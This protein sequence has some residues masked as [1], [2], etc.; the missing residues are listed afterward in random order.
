MCLSPLEDVG[1]DGT[2]GEDHAE[3]LGVAAGSSGRDR[4][5]GDDRR[6]GHRNRG[7][8]AIGRLGDR[9]VGDG[10][11]G[12]VDRRLN[13]RVVGRSRVRHGDGLD[14]DVDRGGQSRDGAG[15][16]AGG[17][18]RDLGGR[19]RDVSLDGRRNG[20]L[21]VGRGGRIVHLGGGV[22][23]LRD[24]VS[25]LD[26]DRADGGLAGGSDG[27]VDGAVAGAVGDFGRAA[28]DGAD[29]SCSHSAGGPGVLG[30]MGLRA[31]VNPVPVIVAGVVAVVDDDI[32]GRVP[33]VDALMAGPL[34]GAEEAKVDIDAQGKV[35]VEVEERS[36]G[37]DGHDG[38]GGGSSLDH[39]DG[40]EIASEKASD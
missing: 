2:C 17:V 16:D 31:R 5:D 6:G 13:G 19:L 30:L 32:V 35:D 11:N 25:S 7:V 36:L 12:S 8:V 15:P 28:D 23:H 24:R 29:V 37:R 14:G 20:D 27:G 33:E 9:R 3:V 18:L 21:G 1:G 39:F 4:R 22:R 34:L 38:Q 40:W 26:G 10:D